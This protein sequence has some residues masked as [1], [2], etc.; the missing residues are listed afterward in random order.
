MA[1]WKYEKLTVV[2]RVHYSMTPQYLV[3]HVLVLLRTAKKFLL[4]RPLFG[5]V[6]VAVVIMVY[7]SSLITITTTTIM[8]AMTA[9]GD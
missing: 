4:I 9:D 2:I 8:W 1:K 6:F 3:I 5:D 7:L